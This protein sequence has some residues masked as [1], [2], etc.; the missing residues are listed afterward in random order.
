[1]KPRILIV[2]DEPDA[3]ELIGLKLREAGMA[4]LFAHDGTH[5]ISMARETKPELI[6]LDLVLPEMDGLEVCKILQRDPRTHAIPIVILTGRASEMDRVV[7]LELGASDYVTKPFSPREL[8]LRVRNILTR[9]RSGNDYFTGLEVPGLK[10]NVALHAILVEGKTVE[11][12]PTEFDLLLALARNRGRV[13]TRACLLQTV[14][15]Y[16]DSVKS[17]TVDTHIN[18][19][20]KKLGAAARYIE[21]VRGAGYRFAPEW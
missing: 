15:G 8:A 19:L 1:M 5:A 13:Q 11:L 9:G 16:E 6:I 10:I 7:G 14:F 3:L 2:D 18:R 20:Q 21:A 12:T 17:R 4:P